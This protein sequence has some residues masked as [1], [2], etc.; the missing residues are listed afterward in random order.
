LPVARIVTL[1]ILLF[2]VAV[3]S[4]MPSLGKLIIKSIPRGASITVNGSSTGQFT[5]ALFAV[6][7]G[8]YRVSV[9]GSANCGDNPVTLKSGETKTLTC[10]GTTWQ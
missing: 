6:A 7:P 2:P 8:T 1:G 9:S 4:Q 3:S 5:D 10:N